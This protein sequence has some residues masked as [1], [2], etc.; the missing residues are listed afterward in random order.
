MTIQDFKD[1]EKLAEK[2]ANKYVGKCSMGFD[3]LYSA[4][5]E[6]MVIAFNKYDGSSRKSG[7]ISTIM[8]K[9][10][11]IAIQDECRTVRLPS[12]RFRKDQEEGVSS[13]SSTSIAGYDAMDENESYDISPILDFLQRYSE[14]DRDII[15]SFFGVTEEKSNKELAEKYDISPSMVTYIIKK[16]FKDIRKNFRI[17]DFVL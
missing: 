13:S 14:R 1:Y 3:E 10:I 15:L 7:Y 12:S 16:V 2:L 5:L 9:T 8:N 4:A 17:E 11:L 6:G